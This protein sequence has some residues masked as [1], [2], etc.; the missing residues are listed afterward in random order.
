DLA[1]LRT[2]ALLDGD[3]YVVD[4]Q[5]IWTSYGAFADWIFA[6]VRTDPDAPKHRGI[7]FLVIDMSTPGVEPRPIVQLDGHAGF[8]EVFFT[9][10]R[11][12]AEN[13][14]GEVNGGWGVAM[15]TIGFVRE[16]AAA[17]AGGMLRSVR[18]LVG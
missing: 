3:E 7:T 15:T 12:P 10:A 9:G 11:V 6:L 17:A 13:V 5:K 8:A 1:G 4:G 2:R 14:V 18:G 16:E